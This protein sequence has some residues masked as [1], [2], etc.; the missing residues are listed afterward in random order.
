MDKNQSSTSVCAVCLE[1]EGLQRFAH[2]HGQAECLPPN[3]PLDF[4][5][6]ILEFV[7]G[8]LHNVEIPQAPTT[9]MAITAT[10]AK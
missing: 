4:T 6:Q 7:P 5:T 10:H 8:S 1:D 2:A 3:G 9:G